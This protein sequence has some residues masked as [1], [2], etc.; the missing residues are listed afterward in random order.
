[1]THDNEDMHRIDRIL[2]VAHQRINRFLPEETHGL[3]IRTKLLLAAALVDD[4][5]AAEVED[6]LRRIC[7]VEL[8]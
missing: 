8:T 5:D 6:L 3:S 1:M 2:F 4:D 7:R